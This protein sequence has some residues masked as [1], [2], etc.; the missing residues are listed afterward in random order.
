MERW[1]VSSFSSKTIS[2]LKSTEMLVRPDGSLSPASHPAAYLAPLRA[3]LRPAGLTWW[4]SKNN[5]S[6]TVEW[7]GAT[8]P[9]I[10][11]QERKLNIIPFYMR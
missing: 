8:V 3:G 4:A 10:P 11:T 6:V 5:R 7:A 2:S 9:D 1:N